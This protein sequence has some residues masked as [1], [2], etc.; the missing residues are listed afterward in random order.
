MAWSLWWTSDRVRHGLVNLWSAPIFHPAADTFALS[1][2]QLLTGLLATP[3]FLLGAGPQ[4]AHNLVLLGMLQAN[5]WLAYG[6]LRRFPVDRLPAALGGLVVASLPFLHQEMGVLTLVPLGGLVG[7]LWAALEYSRTPG[8]RSGLVLGVALAATCLMCAQYGLFV[9]LVGAPAGVFLVSRKLLTVPAVGGL[10][11]GAVLAAALVGPMASAQW[12]AS[13][14]NATERSDDQV[15][16]GSA[17]GRSWSR[18]SWRQAVPL[19][20]VP[21]ADATWRRSLFPGTI[22]LILM[23]IGLG[24]ALRRSE[25]EAAAGFL[26]AVMLLGFFFSLGHHL[27]FGSLDLH[28]LLRD[29]VPG[30]GQIR[31][32]FRF[33]ILTQI[34]V[35]LLAGVGLQAL[36]GRIPRWALVALGLLAAFE[37]H[38]GRPD[39]AD[40]PTA[41]DHTEL[42][43]WIDAETGPDEPLAI[44]PAER[45]TNRVGTSNH[46]AG[47]MLLQTEHGRPLLNGYSSYFPPSHTAFAEAMVSFPDDAAI[48]LLTER[49]VRYVIVDLGEEEAVEILR[50][51]GRPPVL[52]TLKA[53][54]LKL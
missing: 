48:A 17:S 33:A 3:F 34:A 49:G 12:R 31:S 23:V 30:W 15:I 9:V 37:I 41:D 5:G 29:V 25:R 42:L 51:W 1:E 46:I 40:G 20:G 45:T 35:G 52:K 19:P 38:P 39:I 36:S 47:W 2:P 7:T 24:W 6:L 16:K 50:S 11:A 13:A 28:G 21:V 43:A 22:K 53:A 10:V 8:L 18:T 14:E 27:R 32:F 44:A 4:L 26:G 54:V